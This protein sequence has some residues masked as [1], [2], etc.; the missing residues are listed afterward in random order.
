MAQGRE[1][2]EAQVLHRVRVGADTQAAHRDALALEDSD[3]TFEQRA[4]LGLAVP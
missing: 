4:L 2:L 1:Q 3:V